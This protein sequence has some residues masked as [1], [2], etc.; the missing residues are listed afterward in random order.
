M[1]ALPVQRLCRILSIRQLV[2]A[3]ESWR[4]RRGKVYKSHLPVPILPVKYLIYQPLFYPV[5]NPFSS[6]VK[7][8]SRSGSNPIFLV[9]KLIMKTTGRIIFKTTFRCPYDT[10]IRSKYNFH[11]ITRIL[12]LMFKFR[13]NWTWTLIFLLSVEYYILAWWWCHEDTETLS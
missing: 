9:K 12:M 8:P 10:I 6:F 7:V 3:S 4:S 11:Q 13:G 5:P 2:E 1:G